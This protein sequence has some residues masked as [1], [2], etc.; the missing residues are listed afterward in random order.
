MFS[1]QRRNSPVRHCG[2]FAPLITR[3]HVEELKDVS[4]SLQDIYTTERPVARK[5]SLFFWPG[6]A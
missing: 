3:Y 5:K 4:A 2:R 6:W 1:V